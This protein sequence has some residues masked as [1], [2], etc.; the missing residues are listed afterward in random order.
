MFNKAIAI[1]K[2]AGR[3]VIESQALRWMFL[4]VLLLGVGIGA[5]FF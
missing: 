1:L 5:Y 4:P 3:S 2:Q